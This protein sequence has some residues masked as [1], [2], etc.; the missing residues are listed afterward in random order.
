MIGKK[1]APILLLSS[2]LVVASP[3]YAANTSGIEKAGDII[4]IAIPAI[5]YG[6]T[7]YKDDKSGRQQFYQAFG[8]NLAVTY[9][10]KA[11]INKERPNGSDD[12]SFPSS[13]TSVAFQGASFIHKRYGLEYSI[14]A[15]IG[16]GFV[17]YSRLEA[18]EHDAVD[19]LAGAALGIASSMY[20]TKN[21]N[22][23]LYIAPSLAPDYYGL[24]VHYQFK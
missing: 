12:K 22:D 16:A 24:T 14:P 19:V 5:A 21:Y 20:L 6:S 17:A 18:D 23:Q 3:S 7:Y 1:Y 2:S 13:H 15:Y 10:L 11:I 4:A 9:G 8:T